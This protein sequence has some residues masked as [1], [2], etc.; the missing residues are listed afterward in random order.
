PSRLIAFG[1]GHTILHAGGEGNV[2]V[3]DRVTGKL[4]ASL[5]GLLAGKEVKRTTFSADGRTFAV[6]AEGAVQAADLFAR[7]VHPPLTP[8]CRTHAGPVSA[9]GRTL[10][11]DCDPDPREEPEGQTRVGRS[12]V[13]LVESATGKERARFPLRVRDAWVPAFSP[14]GR[15]L[16]FSCAGVIH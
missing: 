14:D 10:A 11:L 5:R 8:G 12:W 7:R 9:D 6:A 3:R 15:M 1:P 13:R 16:A 2:V 4:R